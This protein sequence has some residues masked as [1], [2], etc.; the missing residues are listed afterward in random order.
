MFRENRG[1]HVSIIFMVKVCSTATFL[2]DTYFLPPFNHRLC[3]STHRSKMESTQQTPSR[4]LDT[5]RAPRIEDAGLEDCAL[6]SESIKEAFLKA[7][8]AVS[9]RAASIFPHDEDEE[10]DED[11][12]FLKGPFVD[13]VVGIEGE[14][15]PPGP[16]GVE[17]GAG[18]GD[19][20]VD[21]VGGM[22][23]GSGEKG[24]VV[25]VGEAAEGLRGLKIDEKED[26]EGDD[27]RP[28]LVE[29]K[30]IK[31]GLQDQANEFMV[32]KKQLAD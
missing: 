31:P 22:V 20:G 14:K 25:V 2:K 7:A 10:E 12:S 16:C 26:E 21:L 32:Y 11:S 19:E 28:V 4:L 9:S 27:E 3:D 13:G 23:E 18:L 1:S 15:A 6:P 8:S 5:I 29:S 30:L 24:E 17:K